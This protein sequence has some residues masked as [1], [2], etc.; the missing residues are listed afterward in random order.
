MGKKDRRGKSRVWYTGCMACL[1]FQVLAIFLTCFQLEKVPRRDF[2]MY[3]ETD[4]CIYHL[5]STQW[6]LQ[7]FHWSGKKKITTFIVSLK[8]AVGLFLWQNVTSWNCYQWQ[9]YCKITAGKTAEESHHDVIIVVPV[10][11]PVD[12]RSAT[13]LLYLSFTQAITLITTLDEIKQVVFV[14]SWFNRTTVNL[15]ILCA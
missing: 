11:F 13:H 8:T 14:Q 7:I 15:S 9:E 5:L 3:S 1:V 10:C 4:S 2:S 6:K 12:L